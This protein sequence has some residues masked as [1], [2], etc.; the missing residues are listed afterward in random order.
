MLTDIA[1][2]TPSVLVSA[3]FL[4]AVGAFLRHEMMPRRRRDERVSDDISP[5]DTIADAVAR[6]ARPGRDDEDA[7]GAV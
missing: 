6:Q 3:A 7:R 4:F 2:L 1:V 5:D